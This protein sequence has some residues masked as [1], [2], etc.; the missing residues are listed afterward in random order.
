MS[1]L[2]DHGYYTRVTA[3]RPNPAQLIATLYDD[4]Q[5]CARVAKL[6]YVSPEEPGL[7]RVR[8][9]MSRSLIKSARATG[10]A[11]P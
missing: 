2:F 1:G 6:R 5:E 3:T 9:E 11:A 10:V 8:R 7:T 4:P